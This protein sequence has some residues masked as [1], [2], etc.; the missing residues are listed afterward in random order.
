MY[1][2][3]EYDDCSSE[4][5]LTWTPY[6][7]W[8][9]DK[10]IYNK[11]NVKNY[12]IINYDTKEVVQIVDP[13]VTTYTIKNVSANTQY[14]YY[15]LATNSLDNSVTSKS[16]IVT[17]F[18]ETLQPPLYITSQSASYTSDNTK[19]VINYTI[20]PNSKIKD[21]KL[22]RSETIAGPF[23]EII[24]YGGVADR[25]EAIDSNP[26]PT[27]AYYR[28]EAINECVSL[29]YSDTSTAIVPTKKVSASNIII[30]WDEYFKWKNGVS[31][32]KLYR[33]NDGD[34]SLRAI[35]DASTLSFVDD[36][37]VLAG[38]LSSSRIYYKIFSYANDY[39]YTTSPEY[40][41]DSKKIFVDL[42]SEVYIPNAFTPDDNGLNDIFQAYFAFP[43]DNYHMVIYDRY[44][45]KVFETSDSGSDSGW[46]GLLANNK[47]APEGAYVYLIYFT[48]GE[49]QRIEKK[50]NFS[51][52]YP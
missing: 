30:S 26:L 16:N 12:Q 5:T 17:A 21:Y 32:Y 43:P 23:I 20:D 40:V 1:N 45:F 46:N 44:G 36:I 3:I 28:L 11:G 48:T 18:T 27:T 52:I 31:N 47:R 19:V 37:S 38:H 8:G 2:K 10:K 9:K 24:K 50:G 34:S 15:I 39:D 41:A 49:G 22:T 14:K 13:N 25:L 51:L 29:A 7:G 33:Y 4:L 42:S 6:Y 35:K